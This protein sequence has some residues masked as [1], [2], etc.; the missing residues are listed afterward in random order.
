[1]FHSAV[2][3]QWKVWVSSPLLSVPPQEK[4]ESPPSSLFMCGGKPPQP[5][6]QTPQLLCVLED[7]P[8]PSSTSYELHFRKV[9]SA[10]G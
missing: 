8:F 7:A 3:T 9:E 2:W 1:M 4:T 5:N 10:D 6:Y